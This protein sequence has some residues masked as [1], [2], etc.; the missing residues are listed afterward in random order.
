MNA[1]E[2]AKE[3]IEKYQKLD[4]E[5]GGQ[6]DGYL[7]MKIHDAKQCA[8]MAVEEILHCEATEPSNTDWDDCGATAQYYW[9]QRKV[10]AGKF[11]GD[12]KSE[13]Q[14]L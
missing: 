11:W 13:L 7:T 10:D 1:R 5:I 8:L 4:I 9:P 3:L 2:K 12:V 6:Y 14:S